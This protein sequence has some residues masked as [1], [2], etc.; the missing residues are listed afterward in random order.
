MNKNEGLLHMPEP[1]SDPLLGSVQEAVVHAYY[2]DRVRTASG[3]RTRA[4]AGQSVVTVFAGALVA[5]F[6]LTSLA[7]APQLTRAGG[8]VAVGLWLLAAV[9][10]VR[11]I[12]TSVPVGPEA[13]PA[14]RDA[15]SLIEEV[16]KRA[17]REAL[18]ID[19]RQ[20]M[21]NIVSVLA[22]VATVFTFTTALLMEQPD[23]SRRGVLI[24]GAEGQGLLA[25]LCNAPLERLEGDIDV[26]TLGGQ[27]VAITVP[28]CGTDGQ[29]TLRIP[30]SAVAGT[31]TREG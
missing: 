7:N 27:Y 20:S 23:K 11:A 8:C 9:L 26:T 25:T 18:Q 4:Q 24:L 21:A 28:R 14:A 5:T 13:A 31:L 16:L 2:P 15:R 12:A 1:S 6:T 30:R 10:Y 29:V 19:R 17:D 22:L 3:A